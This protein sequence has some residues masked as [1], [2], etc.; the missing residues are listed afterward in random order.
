MAISKVPPASFWKDDL[1]LHVDHVL[2]RVHADGGLEAWVDKRT[3]R[4]LA[5]MCG[6][7][8]FEGI[9]TQKK[10]DAIRALD[11]ELDPYVLVEQFSQFKSKVAVLDFARRVLPSSVVEPCEKGEEDADKTALLFAVFQHRWSDLRLVFHLDKIHKSGFARMKLKGNARKPKKDFKS[12]LNQDSAKKILAAFDGSRRDGLKSEL[13]SVFARDDRI[14]VFIRR[15]ERPDHLVRPGGGVIL[16]YKSEWII[17]HFEDGAKRVDISSVSI[18]IPLEVANRIATAYFGK[19]C[20]YENESVVTYTKQLERFVAH[21][22][23]DSQG[24]LVLVEIAC[25]D[26]PL[27]G[28]PKVKIS[29]PDSRSIGDS[30]SHFEKAVGMLPLERIES[31]KV[32]FRK[33][34]VSLILDPA[35]DEAGAYVV[36]YSDHRLNALERTDFENHMRDVHGITV[37]STEN[38]FKRPA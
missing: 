13:K 12:W 38:R 8:G 35:E 19:D 28:S 29:H 31:V 15:A 23:Q 18:S 21:V 14:L 37:L 5:V 33:K 16:G 2:G 30:I 10:K 1:E 32:L 4:Q 36:R 20:E 25:A 22:R 17:L 9:S 26:S 11:G 7:F 34:R 24:T 6:A 3:G 27:E